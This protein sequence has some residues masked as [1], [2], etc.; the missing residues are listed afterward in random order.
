M[1]PILFNTEM[2]RA[3]LDNRKTV[4]RRLIKPQPTEGR[5][6]AF[7]ECTKEWE[8]RRGY[9][10]VDGIVKIPYKVGDII[11]VRETFHKTPNGQY[12]Y[13]ADNLCNGCTEDGFCVP[14]LVQYHNT[15][16]ICAYYGGYENI[17]WRPSI[18]MPREAARIFLRVTDVTVERLQDI[19]YEDCLS[20]G[21]TEDDINERDACWP[22]ISAKLLFKQIWNSTIKPKDRA[23]YGW[24]ANPYVWCVSFERV[25]KEEAL[26]G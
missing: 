11:Y 12:W 3:I 25:S 16:K 10:L 22:V 21:I 4:T 14:K 5:R 26:N 24:D 7:N 23:I 1:K 13:K 20:E 2:V 6:I 8:Y 17:K 9:E 19:S 18:Q 15:C